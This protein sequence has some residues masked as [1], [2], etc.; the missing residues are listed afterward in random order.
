MTKKAHITSRVNYG[1]GDTVLGL[2]GKEFEVTAKWADLPKS[3]P[4]CRNCVDVS[5][6]ALT[7]ADALIEGTR[8]DF[9]LISRRIERMSE[10]LAA[11]TVLDELA[12]T[13]LAHRDE[14][15][16]KAR[17]ESERVKAL[18]TCICIWAT[19]ESFEENPDCPIHGG[20][21]DA[22]GVEVPDA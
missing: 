19:P 17:Q 4:I 13:D 11:T 2:C 18:T 5:I 10:A 21:L 8:M 9:L 7:E 3:K 14:L 20:E 12:E 15:E 22:I 6:K 1:V 16:M